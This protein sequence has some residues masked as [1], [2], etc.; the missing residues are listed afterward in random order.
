MRLTLNHLL[1]TGALL[2]GVTCA[3]RA[4]DT[5]PSY[6]EILVDDVKYVITSPSR[7]QEK[8]WQ[9]FG[10]AAISVVGVA[11]IIDRPVRD[12]MRRHAPNNN[13]FMLKVERFGA[14]Y[15]AG[16]AGGF[17]LAGLMGN[18]TAMEV[19]QNGIAASLIASGL[20]TP[21]IKI[22]VGRAR[23]REDVGIAKFHPFSIGYSSNSSFPSGHT[24]EA[25][26]MASVIA[27]HYEETWVTCASYS[28]A[29]LVGVARIYHHAHFA[30]DVLA[31][32][33]IGTLVGKSVVAHNKQMRSGQMALLPEIT[34]GIVGVRVVGK[35]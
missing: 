13:R 3:A 24:T 29:G 22:I 7:W 6:P 5:T 4:T 15:S 20:I 32:G 31:G 26:A 8:E 18:E 12:E 25:F 28:V 2:L 11:A 10:L 16:V 27:N 30:S 34:P 9:D 23:P 19:A 1:C 17:F 14:E 21:A 33:L 35:F